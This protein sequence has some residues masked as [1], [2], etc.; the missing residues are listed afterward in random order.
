MQHIHEKEECKRIAGQ[1]NSGEVK[2]NVP[3]QNWEIHADEKVHVLVMQ[4]IY[5][6]QFLQKEISSQS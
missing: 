5:K 2:L 6:I 3:T 4:R 1:K